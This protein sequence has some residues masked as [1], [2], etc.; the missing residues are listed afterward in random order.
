M[1][2]MPNITE[3]SVFG[4]VLNRIICLGS[5]SYDQD[6]KRL[7]RS[8]LVIWLWFGFDSVIWLLLALDLWYGYL[9]LVR[10]LRASVLSPAGYSQMV[11][12]I[13]R[14]LFGSSL[15]STLMTY[16]LSAMVYEGQ[17]LSLSGIVKLYATQGSS[18]TIY[19]GA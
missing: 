15:Q 16:F 18:T 1:D 12:M 2:I 3:V 13:T 6:S 19:A 7:L 4:S 14:R 10:R 11:S 17:S 5:T 9:A 8:F